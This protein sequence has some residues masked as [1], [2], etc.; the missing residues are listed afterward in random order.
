MDRLHC[1]VVHRCDNVPSASQCVREQ[2]S[3]EPWHNSRSPQQSWMRVV[4]AA[5]ASSLWQPVTPAHCH[6]YMPTAGKHCQF[7]IH[8]SV[9]KF[10]VLKCVK[11]RKFETFKTVKN[12]QNKWSKVI[13]QKASS[14]PH[15]DGSIVF[16]RWRQCARHLTTLPWTRPSHAVLRRH[17]DRFS[18]FCRAHDRDRPTDRPTDHATPS[19]TISRRKIE[20]LKVAHRQSLTV[21]YTVVSL[22]KRS[23]HTITQCSP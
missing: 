21:H 1:S 15:V 12:M 4:A 20:L 11:M 22:V 23:N 14:P 3:V 9:Y 2:R 19:V 17:L 16:A 7:C 13:W 8:C 10:A 6:L 18:G 5:V